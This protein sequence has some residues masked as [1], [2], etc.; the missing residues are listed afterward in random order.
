M[1]YRPAH[2]NSK[3]GEAWIAWQDARARRARRRRAG[4]DRFGRPTK[5]ALGT[6]PRALGTNPRALGTNPRAARGVYD[7]ADDGRTLGE[8]QLGRQLGW[9]A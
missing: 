5:R 9:A 6:N 1:S 8:V 7:V 2:R 3:P 4:L